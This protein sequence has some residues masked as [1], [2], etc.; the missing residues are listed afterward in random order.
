MLG[1]V[2][3]QERIWEIPKSV[4]GCVHG[5]KYSFALIVDGVCV[6]RYD[7]ERGKGDH[8]HFRD[9]ESAYAFVSLE[10]LM[11]A[12]EV[13]VHRILQEAKP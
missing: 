9:Q 3:I 10:M 4:P 6:L 5:Y 13:D 1:K 12:F 7:N 8:R 11:D 2:A